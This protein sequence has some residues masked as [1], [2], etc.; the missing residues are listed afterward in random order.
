[1]SVG[2]A[3]VIFDEIAG[4]DDVARIDA[5]PRL[6]LILSLI[7]LYTLLDSIMETKNP[8]FGHATG[9][10]LIVAGLTSLWVYLSPTHD[11]EAFLTI[12]IMFSFLLPFILI[13]EGYNMHRKKFFSQ[14]CNSFFFGVVIVI[15]NWVLNAIAFWFM[16]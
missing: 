1:M 6:M 13:N 12:K 7:F 11:L 16:F 3:G 4:G 2:A 10:V 8:R 15:L 14:T 5:L 9:V